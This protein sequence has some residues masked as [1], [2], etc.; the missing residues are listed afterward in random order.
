MYKPYQFCQKESGTD[1]W[2]RDDAQD[3]EEIREAFENMNRFFVRK[4]TPVVLSEFGCIDKDNTESRRQLI[5]YYR[6]LADEYGIPCIWWD[7][8]SS[9][10]LL[11]RENLVWVYPD[12]VSALTQ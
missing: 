8:G 10:Q 3:T 9:Y 5:M 4:G 12:L 11:D 1:E 6:E 2:S 7:N